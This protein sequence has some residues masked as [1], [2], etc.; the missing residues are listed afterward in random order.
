MH[1]NIVDY[2]NVLHGSNTIQDATSY[3]KNM[4]IIVKHM[5]VSYLKRVSFG[6]ITFK[7]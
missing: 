5:V 4:T 6:N 3:D 2:R 1:I 7:D